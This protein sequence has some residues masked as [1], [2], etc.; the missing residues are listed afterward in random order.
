MNMNS[1]KSMDDILDSIRKIVHEEETG[2]IAP[3]QGRVSPNNAPTGERGDM[4]TLVLTREM[5]VDQDATLNLS[6]AA[7]VSDEEREA[8]ASLR[9]GA[10]GA[11]KADDAKQDAMPS[12]RLDQMQGKDSDDIA[13]FDA[14]LA[15]D[16]FDEQEDDVRDVTEDSVVDDEGDEAGVSAPETSGATGDRDAYGFAIPPA[17]NPYARRREEAAA[18]RDA[19]AFSLKL[20][21]TATE[22]DDAVDAEDA[23]DDVVFGESKPIEHA[24]ETPETAVEMDADTNDAAPAASRDQIERMVR[25]AVRE[26]LSGALGDKITRNIRGMVRNEIKRVM[27]T[28]QIK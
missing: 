15:E 21:R 14:A 11:M 18:P 4:E 6:R 19:G 1:G 16:D 7:Q 20:N 25:S 22:V 12:L 26:E 2:E 3:R 8:I 24:Q 27:E 5:R 9:L 28:K 10:A 23:A 13:A 17:E